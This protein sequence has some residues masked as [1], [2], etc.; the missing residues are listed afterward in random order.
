MIDANTVLKDQHSNLFQITSTAK[1]FSN[2]LTVDVSNDSIFVTTYSEYGKKELT[3]NDKYK[4]SGTFLLRKDTQHNQTVIESKGDLAVL[5][6]TNAVLHFNFERIV[7]L[8]DRPVPGLYEYQEKAKE[9]Y[10]VQTKVVIQGVECRHSIINHGEFGQSYDAQ[11]ANLELKKSIKGHAGTFTE[12]TRAAI[13]A[14]GPHHAGHAISYALWFK[15][16]EKKGSRILIAYEGHWMK[17][18][19]MNLKLTNG[20]LELCHTPEQ[21]LMMHHDETTVPSLTNNRWHHVAVVMPY[22]NCRLSQVEMYIDG[23]Q[24]STKLRGNDSK[25]KF[26]SGGSISI[27]GFGYSEREKRDGFL[28]G[29]P[30]I[31]EI[32]E[33]FVWARRLSQ[34]E[35]IE[36]SSKS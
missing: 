5:N 28:T 10:P 21:K 34:E 35:I 15:T 6:S 29:G 9:S 27:G 3:F 7:S 25:A 11:V 19:V 16:K 1:Y 24:V 12:T 8:K 26:P 23:K 2:F 33:V 31:G 36:L 17:P 22:K 30:F 18:K 14:M 32:D 4:V 13:Y 20:N